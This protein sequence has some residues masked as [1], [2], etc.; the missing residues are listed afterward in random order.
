MWHS[1]QRE[2]AYQDGRL[3]FVVIFDLAE[4]QLDVFVDP[5]PAVGAIG[6]AQRPRIGYIERQ[7]RIVV[8]SCNGL[9]ILP[10]LDLHDP[11]P[12]RPFLDVLNLRKGEPMYLLISMIYSLRRE[13]G[14]RLDLRQNLD[15]L[16]LSRRS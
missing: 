14:S 3:G 7:P 1:R 15:G 11:D 8:E 10:G 13:W 6:T 9:V 16:S 5:I 2:R 12:T 4:I